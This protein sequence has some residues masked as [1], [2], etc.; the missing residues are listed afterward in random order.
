MN[1]YP[2]TEGVFDA[3]CVC[4][5]SINRP[6]ADCERCAMHDWIYKQAAEFER[7]KDKWRV[8]EDQCD[9]LGQA[10]ESIRQSLAVVEAN[11][12]IAEEEN[13]RLRAM[14]FT[15]DRSDSNATSK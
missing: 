13:Q 10:I 3:S 4:G 1:E 6:N 7:I 5:G 11:R 15:K 9:E 8:K 12:V 2:W 14:M